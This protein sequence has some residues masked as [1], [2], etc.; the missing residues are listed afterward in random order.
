[1]IEVRLEQTMQLLEKG[2]FT[3]NEIM[4]R[5]GFS[6]QSHF[7]RSFKKKFGTTPREYRLKKSLS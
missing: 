6:N 1:M 4:E 5:T 2:N 3:V 7:F